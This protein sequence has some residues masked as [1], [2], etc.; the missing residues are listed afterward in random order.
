MPPFSTE[1]FN[2]I[3]FFPDDFIKFLVAQSTENMMKLLV[4]K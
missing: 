2:L 1:Y 4:I 3:T